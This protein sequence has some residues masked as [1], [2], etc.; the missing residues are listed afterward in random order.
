MV[1]KE[2]AQNTLTWIDSHCHLDFPEF[3]VDREQV[4]DTCSQQ[5]MV[6]IL[7]PG[8]KTSTWQAL[9]QLVEAQPLLHRAVG[10]H[11]MFIEQ[12][13]WGDL[14]KL[15]QEIAEFRPVAVGE[16]GLDYYLKDRDRLRQREFFEAQLD[17]AQQAKL[18]VILHV[19]KAHDEVLQ[20][21][22]RRHLPGGVVHAFNGS[23][24]QANQ[25]LDLGFKLGFGGVMTHEKARHVRQL[26]QKLPLAAMVLETDAPDMPPSWGVGQRNSPENIPLIAQVLAELTRSSLATIALATAT[27]VQT[28]FSLSLPNH[29][30]HSARP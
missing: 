22:R 5:G 24:Q 25:Y 15:E 1:G 4:I 9:R 23:W 7:V 8:V 12:H 20:A 11:P 21:L 30:L 28:T 10:L 6:A 26:A 14:A 29:P 18:P 16:I 3:D 17:M 13:Q 19:R 2:P 27:N